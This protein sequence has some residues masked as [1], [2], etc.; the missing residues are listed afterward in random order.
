MTVAFSRRR[1]GLAADLVRGHAE[2]V[3]ENALL[4]QQVI[5]AERKIRGRVRWAPWQRFTM[6]L[7]ARV[8]P[9][10]REATLLVQPATILRW[11]RAGFRAFWRRRSRSSGRPPTSRA[12]LIREMASRNPRWGAERIRGELLKLG[13]RV[14]KRTLQRYMRRSWPRGDGQGWATFLRNHVTWACDFVQTY[15]VRFREIFVLFFLDLRRRK[16]VHAAVTYGPTD[17]WC[18]QQARNATMNVAPEVFLCDQDA[19]LGVRFAGVLTSSGVRVVRT[20]VRA[21]DMNAFAERLA[22]TLRRELLDHFLILGEDHLRRIVTQYVR[23][24][25][26]GRP[27]QA[28]AHQQ[29]IPRPPQTEGR[30][31]AVPVLAGLHH[32]YRRVA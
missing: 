14:S 11:H 17:E 12:A 26:E 1:S 19:N 27:H 13:I 15:D 18:A 31:D 25:N 32:D 23:F 9:A 30:V 20:A 22:G 7:A 29:P 8:A 6:A 28:L 16:I 21:P 24:Y 10:W 5:V 2:L 4:R 3:A